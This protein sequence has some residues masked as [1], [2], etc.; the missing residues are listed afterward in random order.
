MKDLSGTGYQMFYTGQ[1]IDEGRSRIG[2]AYSVLG[3]V[4]NRDQ[5]NQPIFQ[6]QPQKND[7]VDW[8][9]EAATVIFLNNKLFMWHGTISTPPDI[10]PESLILTT[11]D[12]Q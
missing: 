4:W 12:C 5:L 7:K 1:K 6:P 2:H 11:A 9:D 8:A 10:F 3:T